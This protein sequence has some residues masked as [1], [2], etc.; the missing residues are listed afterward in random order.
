MKKIIVLLLLILPVWAFAETGDENIKLTP[1]DVIE[2]RFFYTPELNKVQTIRPDGN[3]VLQLV[4]EVTAAGRT[5]KELTRELQEMYSQYFSQLDIAVFVESYSSRYVYV[6]GEVNMPGDIAF[7]KNLTVLEA[8]LLA[9]G[10]ISENASYKNVFV[11]RQ[12][13]GKWKWH[14]LNLENVLLGK[15]DQ[16]FYLQPLDIVYVPTRLLSP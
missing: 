11:I 6:G 2:I 5:P 10:I 13:E 15:K 1:G 3:I 7:R 4:G 9:G 12:Q 16:P 8:I 14:S